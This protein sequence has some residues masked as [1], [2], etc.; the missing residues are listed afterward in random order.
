MFRNKRVNTIYLCRQKK[1]WLYIIVAGLQNA[2]Q[3]QYS[4]QIF[5]QLYKQLSSDISEFI[6]FLSLLNN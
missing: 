2:N 4:S 3:T 6:N 5:V 1:R